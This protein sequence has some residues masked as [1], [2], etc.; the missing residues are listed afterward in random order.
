MFVSDGRPVAPPLPP[1]GTPLRDRPVVG[2]AARETQVRRPP[3]HCLVRGPE[4]YAGPHPGV[5][6]TRRRAPDGEWLF[7][8]VWVVDEDGSDEGRSVV[9]S[10]VEAS[11]VTPVG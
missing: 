3:R 9:Q 6:V 10:W 8:V 5:I 4:G 2:P 7:L 11:L 1:R